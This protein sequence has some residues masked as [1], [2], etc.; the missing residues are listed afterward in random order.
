MRLECAKFHT[1]TVRDFDRP[2]KT[3]VCMPV[4]RGIQRRSL[5][6]CGWSGKEE[7]GGYAN[8]AKRA[9]FANSQQRHEAGEVKGS[10]LLH[11]CFPSI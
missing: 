11:S 1:G 10:S 2:I 9:Q 3:L 7:V 4:L 5:W 8:G 6:E